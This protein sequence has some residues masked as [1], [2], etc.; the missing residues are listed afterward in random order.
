MFMSTSL[1]STTPSI[2]IRVAHFRSKTSWALILAVLRVSA[3]RFACE[4]GQKHSFNVNN[5]STRL[6][7]CTV[8]VY[9][10]VHSNSTCTHTHTC[11]RARS[12]VCTTHQ[13]SDGTAK[14]SN[15]DRWS[16]VRLLLWNVLPILTLADGAFLQGIVWFVDRDPCSTYVQAGWLARNWINSSSN[17]GKSW[18]I[19]S[20]PMGSRSWWS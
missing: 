6:D 10:Y 20:L 19:P 3:I 15:Y 5:M 1:S 14:L 13:H 2:Q 8:Y 9:N 17:V 16:M 12:T 4:N 11:V 7:I 18:R